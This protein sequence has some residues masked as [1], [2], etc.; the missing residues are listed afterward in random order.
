MD[1][2]LPRTGQLVAGSAKD[3]DGALVEDSLFV[4]DRFF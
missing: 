3:Q 4:G 2:Y 1:A